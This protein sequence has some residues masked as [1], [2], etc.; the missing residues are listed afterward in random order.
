MRIDLRTLNPASPLAKRITTALA[1]DGA[2]RQPVKIPDKAAAPE[3]WRA[4]EDLQR[5]V[6]AVLSAELVADAIAFHVPNGGKRGKAEA[7]RLKAMGTLAGV[8][9][10][11]IIARGTLFGLELK[12][13]A[14]RLS[15]AQKTMRERFTRTGAEYALAR[16]VAEAR[17][18]LMSWR[19]LQPEADG[20]AA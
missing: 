9:D 16:S 8:P 1:R 19:V 6:M 12:T 11:L 14:G 10:I 7:G 18:H 15:A 20:Q 2:M 13:P 17:D 3:G 5:L 4:E